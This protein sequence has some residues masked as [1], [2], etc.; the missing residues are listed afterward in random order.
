MLLKFTCNTQALF[1]GQLRFSKLLV[2]MKITAFLVFVACI[3]VS[4]RGHAQ[5]VSLSEKNGSL[6]SIFRSIRKQTGYNFLYNV[7]WLQHARP[8][9]IDI[10]EAPLE[11]A[12]NICFA[13]QPFTYTIIKNTIALELKQKAA[14]PGLAAPSITVQGMVTG[15]DGKPLTGV[16]VQVK[17]SNIGTVTDVTGAYIVRPAETNDTLVFSYVGYIPREIPIDGRSNIDIHLLVATSGLNQLVVVGYG[18][19]EKKDLTSAI[20]TVNTKLLDNRSL[21]NLSS[22]L[23][24]ITPGVYIQQNNG[25]PGQ[26]GASSFNIRGDNL[27]TFSSN[28]PLIIIDGVVDNIDDVNPND[29][30]SISILKDAAASA[31]YGARASGGVVLITTKRGSAGKLSVTYNGTYGLQTQPYG[32][33]KFV[34]TATWMRA[35]NEAAE[36]DGQNDI[37]TADKIAKYTNSKNPQFPNTTQWTSW[38]AK[39]APQQTHNVSVRGG[40]NEIN[41]FLSGGLLKQGGFIPHDSYSRKSALLNVDYHHNK[42]KISANI[43]Y[44]RDDQT[45]PVGA[46]GDVYSLVRD[47]IVDPPTDPLYYPNGTF[48]NIITLPYAGI[49]PVN[50]ITNGGTTTNNQDNLRMSLALDY[51]ILKGLFIDITTA[52]KLTHGIT[53]ILIAKLPILD[54]SGNTL[55]YNVSNTSVS[56][57]WSKQNYVNNQ[58]LLNYTKKIGQHDF[59]IMGGITYEDEYDQNIGAS[60]SQFPN[61]DIR[62]ISGTTGSGSQISGTSGAEEWAINSVIGRLN[63][64]YKGKYLFQAT[65]RYDGS[66]RFSPDKRWGFF[67]SF[68]GAWRIKQE[69]FL[70]DINFI[71]NLKLRASWGQLGNQGSNLYPFAQ[72][73]SFASNAVFG[74]GIVS[75]ATLGG[76]TNLA[77]TWEKQTSQNIGLDFGFLDGRLS[78]SFDHFNERTKNIIGNPPVSS[79]FGANSPLSNLY[80]IDMRGFE[81]EIHWRDHIGAFNYFAGFNLSNSVDK[82]VDLVGLGTTDN[83]AVFGKEPVVISGNSYM[84]LGKSQNQWYLLKTD[85]LFVNQAEIDKSPTQTVVTRPGDIRYVDANGDGVI[86]SDDTRPIGKTS[87]P[88]YIFGANL[89]ISFKNFDL[90]AVINGVWERWNLRNSKGSYIAGV[91][92]TLNLLQVNYDN[93]WTKKN[94]DKW[95]KVPRL[96]QDNWIGNLSNLFQDSEFWLTNFGYLRV[97]NIQIGYTLP[98]RITDKLSI[99]KV[100]IYISAEN[101]ITVKPG[102]IEPID[103][104][105]YTEYEQTGSTYFGPDRLTSFGL[106]V[107]F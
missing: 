45:M 44:I 27:S 82:V 63:Y 18:T 58:F 56:E 16:T 94:P 83:S 90:S 36:L 70:K 76:P 34:N 98:K 73:V 12:L 67:P 88:H 55:G 62:E 51:E 28:P 75:T 23:A 104:E 9:S 33:L 46:G 53:N 100:R 72:A 25:R 107:T 50:L 4:A 42:L 17:G 1:L 2:M 102:Y 11:Q 14:P 59:H 29:I 8:V 65:G 78:S 86:N 21:T 54:S 30:A 87:T 66:S 91:R 79:T 22:A 48:N 74:N 97:K 103:P 49:N 52:T 57:G 15:Q 61:N 69:P 20:T 35:N 5:T 101:L 92:P 64:S 19:T 68:S 13:N 41:F 105:S 84:Q 77:L 39:T 85:G 7:A 80:T 10:K 106:N 60:A 96:T 24:G 32:D 95:A 40:S 93:R 81:L 89:G 71:S 31:I 6:E 3:Q 26:S 43:A 47:A 99:T 38:I 37:Y